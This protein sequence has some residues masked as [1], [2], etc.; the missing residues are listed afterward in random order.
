[1]VVFTLKIVSA[2]VWCGLSAAAPRMQVIHAV[3]LRYN[4]VL[5]ILKHWHIVVLFH[6]VVIDE[7]QSH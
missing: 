5:D 7:G 6:L 2:S 1:V 3:R 4:H